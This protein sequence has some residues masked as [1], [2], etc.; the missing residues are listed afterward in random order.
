MKRIII[1]SILFSALTILNSC[2][3]EDGG[4]IPEL[5]QVPVVVMTPDASSDPFINPVNPALFKTK[6]LVELLFPNDIKPHNVDVVVMKNNN[7]GN[8]KVAKAGIALSS[9]VEITGQQLIALFGPINGGDQFMIG[10]DV[11]TAD[12]TKLLAF[13]ALGNAVAS[14]INT[15]VGNLKPNAAVVLQYLVPCAFDATKYQGAF[16]VVSDEWADYKPGT[17]ITVT[18]INATQIS[19]KYNVDPGSAEPIILTIN[20]ATNSVSV[21]NQYYGSYGGTKVHAE[22]V[23]GAAS[24]VNPCDG[25]ISVRLKHTSPSGA[26]TYDTS[27]IVLKKK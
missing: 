24:S 14:G 1:F 16:E 26:T 25:T 7:T 4:N 11:T 21:A 13:P 10:T 6:F 8:V 17:E 19:F 18:M 27:T 9:T 12:G 23:A 2:D 5:K 22:S 20:P 15:E 3:K